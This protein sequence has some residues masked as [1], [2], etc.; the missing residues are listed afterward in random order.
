MFK[1]LNFNLDVITIAYRKWT[2]EC[3]ALFFG[4]ESVVCSEMNDRPIDQQ[5]LARLFGDD[6]DTQKAILLEYS[7]SLSSYQLEF[8]RAVM[9]QSAAGVQAVAHKMK[10]SSRTVGAAHLAEEC[11]AL[12]QAGRSGDWGEIGARSGDFV[13]AIQAV[14]FCIAEDL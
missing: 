7:A 11:E 12:E 14:R 9:E 3:S 13:A 2:E 6:A 8:E 10:S 5:T 4:F 1:P